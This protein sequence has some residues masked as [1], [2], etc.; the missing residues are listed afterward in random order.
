MKVLVTPTSMTPEKNPEA[1]EKLK[2][3]TEDLVFNPFGRPMKEEELIEALKDCD[4]FI[5]GVD[6]VTEKVLE[7]CP[8]LKVISRY[9][10]GYDAVDIK[11][12]RAKGIDVTNTPA[13]NSESVGELA[14]GMIIALARAIPYL[15][16]QTKTGNWVRHS[17]M[18]LHGKTMGIIGF[19]AIGRVVGRCAQGFGM[20]V[21]AYDPYMNEAYCKENQIAVKTLDEV[22]R[23]ADVIS[24]HLPLNDS[25]RHMIDKEAISKMRDGVII[26]NTARGGIVDEAAVYEALVSGKVAGLGLDVYEVEP[27][28]GS[29]LF[30]LDNVI[31]TPHAGAHT[32]A[33]TFKMADM[34]IDN[35]VEV[36]TGK[37]CSHIVNR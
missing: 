2:R 28:T 24:T 3:F 23:E 17:G 36:L 9:G 15:S 26:I 22:I 35:L 30:E 10:A 32:G 5:A 27:P 11:A 37:E 4:G 7:N 29:P 21:I 8:N 31:A 33:A 19:G 16:G 1:I 25:T 13:V 12:A 34:A 14:F 20:N 6:P 18:E